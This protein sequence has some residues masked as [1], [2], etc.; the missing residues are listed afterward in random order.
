MLFGCG[1]KTDFSSPDTVDLAVNLA[2]LTYNRGM[3]S[4]TSVLGIQLGPLGL[5]CL[6]S[7]DADRI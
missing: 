2:V 3:K 5:C 6:D 4:L 1:S 7:K